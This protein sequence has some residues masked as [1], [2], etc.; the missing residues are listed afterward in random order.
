VFIK[1][2]LYLASLVIAAA[3][4][5]APFYFHPPAFTEEYMKESETFS[6]VNEAVIP[7]QQELAAIDEK[8]R[9]IGDSAAQSEH[10]L[11]EIRSLLSGLI[12]NV[13]YENAQYI[14]Q[15]Q[16]VEVLVAASSRQ[17][18]ESGDV[19]DT[20]LSNIL[21][22]PIGQTYGA[23]ATI[24]VFSL[25]E[26]GYRGYMAKVKVHDP[27]AIRL[28][29]S[30]DKVGDKGETTSEAAKK[31]GAAL[32]INGGGFARGNDGL[33]Y[34]MG[35]TVVDGEI[36][37]FYRTDL[38]FIGFN[39]SGN[40]VGGEI[41]GKE[42]I[43]ELGIMHGATFVPT[44]LKG[45]EK[46]EIPANW[47]NKKEPRTLIGHFS[48][49]DLLFIVIDGRQKGYSD[50]VTLEEAQDKLLEFNVR[51]AYTLDGGGSSTF[52]YDGKVLNHPSDGMER[53]L[54]SS[55]VITP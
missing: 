40:L 4:F 27:S 8:F 48:N 30:N 11:T 53:R 49:G 54:A 28:V 7:I 43:E 19:L 46:Q 35:I 2:N 3:A 5:F 13:K 44:L 29:L 10:K 55:F 47:K 26:A 34:P 16:A 32:A 17:V 21:G 22:D 14:A 51:D 38:S 24:K 18:K 6:S 15:K 23:K 42:R 20:I 25:Q 1:A 31:T 52:Y 33:L 45:G 41:T 12:Q 36:K 37:T 9:E 50:G 39:K